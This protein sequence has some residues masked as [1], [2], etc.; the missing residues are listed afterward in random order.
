MQLLMKEKILIMVYRQQCLAERLQITGHLHKKYQNLPYRQ[1]CDV[2]SC[3]KRECLHIQT[4]SPSD[5]LHYNL[6]LHFTISLRRPIQYH[7]HHFFLFLSLSCFHSSLSVIEIDASGWS[8]E[9]ACYLDCKAPQIHSHMHSDTISIV[10]EASIVQGSFFT[11][12]RN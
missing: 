12:W 3:L 4:Q 1:Q 8:E 6:E 2:P 9:Q 5:S 10:H 11:L 7:Y